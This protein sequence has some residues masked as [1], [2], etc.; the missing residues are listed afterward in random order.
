MPSLNYEKIARYYDSYVQADFDL[1]FFLKEAKKVSGK[2]LELM[3]GTGRVS[4]LLLESGVDLTCIDSSLEMLNVFRKKLKDKNISANV[5]EMDVCDM[6]LGEKF[7]LIFIPFHAFAELISV[8]RQHLALEKIYE[9]LSDDGRFICTLH[10]PTVRLRSADG[11]IRLIGEFPI[12][13]ENR[14]LFLWCLENY[15]DKKKIVSGYQFYE[16]YDKEGK[17]CSKSVLDINF[18]IH[19]K[20]P[21]ELLVHEIGFKIESLYGDYSWGDYVR[22]VSPEMVWVLRK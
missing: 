9:H 3:S 15:D 13:D 6:S 7:D 10:N 2:V 22:D 5:F 20:L 18:Y 11:D 16:I 21:F 4:I 12:K 1:N 19:D 8:S 17:F 14:N